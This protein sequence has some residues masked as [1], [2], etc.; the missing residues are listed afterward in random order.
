[1]TIRSGSVW[2]LIKRKVDGAR[3]NTGKE[4]EDQLY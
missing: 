2:M 1:M 3:D 4:S